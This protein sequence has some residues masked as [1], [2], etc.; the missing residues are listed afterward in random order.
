M[1]LRTL[2]WVRSHDFSLF[3]IS[4]K[5]FHGEGFVNRTI[6]KTNLNCGEKHHET[7]TP[8]TEILL[9]NKDDTFPS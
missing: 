2:S 9:F 4:Q 8:V 3:S 5:P 7:V 6:K 1:T